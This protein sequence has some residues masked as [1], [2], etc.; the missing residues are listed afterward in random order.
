[1]AHH[2]EDFLR[3][4]TEAKTRI[5]QLVP[6]EARQR[7]TQ[8]GLLLDVRSGEE[9]AEGHIE[10]AYNLPAEELAKQIARL[11]PDKQAPILCYCRGGNRGALAADELQRLGYA[12]V[13]SIEGGLTAFLNASES[14]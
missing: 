3:R 7:I 8:G 12:N 9:Y 2:D 10:G 4:A 1:M 11:Q 6:E 5:R 14:E 13:A